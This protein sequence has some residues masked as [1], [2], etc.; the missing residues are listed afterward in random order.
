MY[1][2][3][4]DNDKV[5]FQIIK[6][7]FVKR[8]VPRTSK[9]IYILW[10]GSQ[11]H[12][13]REFLR[14][15]LVEQGKIKILQHVKD[16]NDFH[17]IDLASTNDL[18]ATESQYHPSCYTDYTR[19]FTG[20]KW[21]K[22]LTIK[23]L[24]L[25]LFMRLWSCHDIICSPSILIFEKLLLIIKNHFLKNSLSISQST[26]KNLKRN[27]EK[28]FGDGLKFISVRGIFAFICHVSWASN[29]V[30]LWTGKSWLC[31][32]SNSSNQKK[33]NDLASST[34]RLWTRKIKIPSK[35][36]EFS[37]CL[38]TIKEE[39]E[40]SSRR[41]WFRHSLS[42]DIV[43]SSIVGEWKHQKVYYYQVSSKYLQVREHTLSMQEEG[44]EAFTNF[45]KKFRSPGEHRPKYFMAQ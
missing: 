24:N 30:I 28:C 39:N 2:I 44:P 43:T 11:V 8:I 33:R 32:K 29:Y 16:K 34:E 42:Q 9:Q 15:C 19:L 25:R 22:N 40:I 1:H 31:T 6:R 23:S 37:T 36:N 10:C 21:L 35:L 13:K 12:K 27:I 41:A 3:T 4:W 17:L 5:L 7:E 45:S 18:I 38:L 26:K 14:K 20:K